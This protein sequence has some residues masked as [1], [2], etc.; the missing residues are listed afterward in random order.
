M[1]SLNILRTRIAQKLKGVTTESVTFLTSQITTQ[2]NL[3]IDFFEENHMWFNEALVPIVLNQGDPLV[4]NIP[5]DFLHEVIDGGLVINENTARYALRKVLGTEYNYDNNEGL[6][7]PYIYTVR[8]GNIEVYFFPDRPYVLNLRY[9][10][11]YADLVDD[12][13]TNDWLENAERLIEYKT[14]G[15]MYLDYRKDDA[16]AAIYE[17]RVNQEMKKLRKSNQS[18]LASNSLLTE[19]LNFDTGEFTG[20]FQ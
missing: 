6:G 7:R 19:N 5:S 9:I 15:D 14:L 18:R 3:S 4:P 11:S 20:F 12:N 2:I 13:D 17:Q 8:E 16:M 10:K 1:T